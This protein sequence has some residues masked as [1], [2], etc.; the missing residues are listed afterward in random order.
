M[1]ARKFLGRELRIY[2]EAFGYSQQHTAKIVNYTRSM[3]TRVESGERTI[4]PE[5]GREFDKLYGLNGTF[6]RLAE[7]AA[8][9]MTSFADYLTIEGE[10]NRISIYDLRVVPGLLQTPDYARELIKVS[11][12]RDP[13][14]LFTTRMD[15]QHILDSDD[16]PDMRVVL[17]ESVL[18]RVIG[19]PEIMRA[20]FERLLE[21]NHPLTVQILPFSAGA[22]AGVD[23]PLHILD[24][25]DQPSVAYVDGRGSG[26]LLVSGE[27]VRYARNVYDSILSA[28]L[29][30]WES[31]ELIASRLEGLVR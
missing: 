25:P 28:A 29:S 31:A 8:Q 24:F 22:H 2:R 3:I 18:H 4:P 26:Q 15:Q 30:P 9:E 11:L 13:K 20:Q 5:V 16:P 17:D 7:E 21:P 6:E 10:A 12:V 19:G 1:D 14:Q 27:D 23:G